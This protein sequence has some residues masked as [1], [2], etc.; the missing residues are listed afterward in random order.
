MAAADSD[1]FPVTARRAKASEVN[2]AFAGTDHPKVVPIV[3][4]K[5]KTAL[6]LI[7][8]LHFTTRQSGGASRIALGLECK[9][10]RQ[11]H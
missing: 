10:G 5:Q 4:K 8:V 9:S 2:A 3:Q 7:R 11:L 1:G 6:L